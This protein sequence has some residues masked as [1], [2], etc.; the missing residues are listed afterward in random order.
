MSR[1]WLLPV[2]ALLTL[3]GTCKAVVLSMSPGSSFPQPGSTLLGVQL[4]AEGTVGTR[5]WNATFDL[6][7][8]LTVVSI[9]P[10]PDVLGSLG[11]CSFD[12]A[13]SRL[14]VLA[15]NLSSDLAAGTA[16]SFDLQISDAAVIGVVL[17]IGVVGAPGCSVTSGVGNCSTAV[18]DQSSELTGIQA[19]LATVSDVPVPRTLSYTPTV[20]STIAFANGAFAG[21][22]A[23][24]QQV[25]VTATGNAGPAGLSECNI[26]GPGAAGFS[27]TP[28]QLDLTTSS[29]RSLTVGCSYAT[30]TASA[31]LSCVEIDGDT[32][33]PGEVRLF[34]LSCPAA[35]Q[36]PDIEPLIGSVPFSGATIVTSGASLGGLGTATIDLTASGGSGAGSVQISCVSS[37]NVRL[38]AFPALPSGQGP[39]SQTVTGSAQPVDLRVGVVLTSTEQVP[40]GAVSCTVSGQPTIVITV[41]APAPGTGIGPIISPP[42]PSFPPPA[43]RPIPAATPEWLSVVAMLVGLAGLLAAGSR[44]SG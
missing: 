10:N 1:F 8:D 41:N 37:G 43:A 3:G 2:F 44:R 15:G 31:T 32:P 21:D 30:V 19:H 38:A 20:G 9:T 14:V 18:T 24:V 4:I 33:A 17:P 29:P 16:C 36:A 6:P 22:S 39:L 25:S 7:P 40:A 27:V 34:G 26:S 23:P 28:T 35:P 42:P 11:S 5:G 12:D 13:S